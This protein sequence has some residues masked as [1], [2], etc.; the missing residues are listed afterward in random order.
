MSVVRSH[1]R[2]RHHNQIMD[3]LHNRSA[4]TIPVSQPGLDIVVFRRKSSASSTTS[5][6]QSMAVQSTAYR[7]AAFM[8]ELNESESEPHEEASPKAQ[9]SVP[10]SK[11]GNIA[12]ANQGIA[13]FPG[14]DELEQA[15]QQIAEW[16]AQLAKDCKDTKNFLEA[17][18]ATEDVRLRKLEERLARVRQALEEQ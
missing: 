14:I 18:A 12:S 1:L 5:F 13:Q 16:K 10:T 8:S 17:S 9:Q 11:Q 2:L 7:N 3:Q 15:R 4:K 6:G